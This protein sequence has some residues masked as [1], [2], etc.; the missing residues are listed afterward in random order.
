MIIFLSSLCAEEQTEIT[1][2]PC[3]VSKESGRPKEFY[4]RPRKPGLLAYVTNEQEHYAVNCMIPT[5][6]LHQTVPT[7]L[8]HQTVSQ[9]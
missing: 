5:D 1:T 9:R 4:A 8:L 2:E 6:L 7:D 3:L